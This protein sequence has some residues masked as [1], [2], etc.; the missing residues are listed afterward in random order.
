MVPALSIGQNNAP[1]SWWRRVSQSV[2]AACAACSRWPG[3]RRR[4]GRDA[5][6]ARRVSGPADLP[7]RVSQQGND[8]GAL[9]ELV[10]AVDGKVDALDRD[11]ELH[12]KLDL[13]IERFSGQ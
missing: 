2:S 12:R 6:Y 11:A 9:Y 3:G 8:I 13:L 10:T 1:V 4:G 7:R 5:R